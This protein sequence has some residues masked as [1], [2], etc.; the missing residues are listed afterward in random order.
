MTQ[1]QARDRVRDLLDQQDS[2]DTQFPTD[3]IDDA[4]NEG[5]RVLARILPLE[6]I[7][8]LTEISNLSLANGYA[9][10]PSD[11]LRHVSD[12]YEQLVD[13]VQS[14]KL[15]GW[16]LRFTLNNDLTKGSTTEPMHYYH[17][18]GVQVYP[19]D[20]VTMTFQYVKVPSDLA[21]GDN[22]D[23][24]KDVEDMSIEYAFEK[25]MGT[26]RGD[27]ELAVFLAKKRGIYLKEAKA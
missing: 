27:T 26:Q 8:D 10:F 19:K 9:V 17:R 24:Q 11:F 4:V 6:M 16:R 22:T 12:N 25:L 18:Q 5:R 3:M 7:P 2:T 15:E 20:S 13:S 21:A 23:L 14:R 1:T